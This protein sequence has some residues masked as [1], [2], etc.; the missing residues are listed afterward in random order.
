MHLARIRK[1]LAAHDS[2]C[3]WQL[4]LAQVEV[5]LVHGRVKER[6]IRIE[7]R[8]NSG[9]SA[10]AKRPEG[11]RDELQTNDHQSLLPR[12][13]KHVVRA[14]PYEQGFKSG[15][16][17]ADTD[18]RIQVHGSG[19]VFED[20]AAAARHGLR[21]RSGCRRMRKRPGRRHRMLMAMRSSPQGLSAP[22]L[23]TTSPVR[24]RR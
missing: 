4:P 14:L 10:D 15:W 7:R 8:G 12:D 1:V 17:R 24:F 6:R 9:R 3:L 21:C 19:H 13:R 18:G 20:V 22:S 11:A 16:S 5:E 23:G 2:H